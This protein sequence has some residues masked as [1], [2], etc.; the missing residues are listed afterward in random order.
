M[1][2][3]TFL[4][5]MLGKLL[6]EGIVVE[7]PL[8]GF[9]LN[10]LLRRPNTRA[11]VCA[12]PCAC[13]SSPWRSAVDDLASLDA[14]LYHSLVKLKQYTGNVEDLALTF[15]IT[16][17]RACQPRCVRGWCAPT[18]AAD[19]NACTR[20]GSGG[21]DDGARHEVELIRGGRDV[22]VTAGSRA[23]YV[24]LLAHYRLNVQIQRG[25]RA[26]LA[27]VQDALDVALLRLFNQRE[28]QTLISGTSA[29]IDVADLAAHTVY[30]APYSATHPTVRGFWEVR[31]PAPAPWRLVGSGRL[32]Q[33]TRGHRWWRG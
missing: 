17:E 14:A 16:L 6:L 27:G 9:F 19:H 13:C 26:F 28:L 31:R 5:R 2:K 32:N 18:C 24:H 22:A 33:P 11:C 12:L 1:A 21:T 15:S 4:G 29:P 30:H 23:A 3:L 8:A 10:A 25:A 20:R 7:L